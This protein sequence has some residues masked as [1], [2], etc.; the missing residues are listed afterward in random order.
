MICP[1][2]SGEK[3]ALCCQKLHQL[4]PAQNALA[5]MRSRYSAYALH[6]PDYIIQTTHPKNPQYKKDLISW[7]RGILRFSEETLFKKL[8]ILE[9]IDGKNE[10]FVTFIAYL[11]QNNVDHL[12]HEKSQ[13]KLENGR[14]LYFDAKFL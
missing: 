14:W 2:C 8:E 9:Y 3:Y 12:L 10:A 6:L 11:N 7:R 5:L 13:F 4:E 1:C